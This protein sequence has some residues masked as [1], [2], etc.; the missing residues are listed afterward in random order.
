MVAQA[1]NDGKDDEVLAMQLL[2][3]KEKGSRVIVDLILLCSAT[4]KDTEPSI[5]YRTQQGYHPTAMQA[6][7]SLRAF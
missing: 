5:C 2:K 6:I 4:G 3:R 7:G 1:G